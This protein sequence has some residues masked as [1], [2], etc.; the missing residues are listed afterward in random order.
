[1]PHRLCMRCMHKHSTYMSLPQL[2]YSPLHP[3]QPAF[4]SRRPN[5][6]LSCDTY[7][8]IQP[9]H[10]VTLTPPSIQ[11]NPGCAVWWLPP[12]FCQEHSRNN[13]IR[14]ATVI[15]LNGNVKTKMVHKNDDIIHV[16]EGQGEGVGARQETQ[17]IKETRWNERPRPE[18]KK[19]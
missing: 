2:P 8:N 14:C 7:F 9:L 15:T 17:K 16:T 10:P 18:Q 3:A 12:P 19:K 1:M 11:Y 13:Q 5:A 4:V 6:L